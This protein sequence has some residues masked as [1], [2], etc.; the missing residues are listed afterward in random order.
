[1]IV[2][3]FEKKN[4]PSGYRGEGFLKF[5]ID[6]RPRNDRQWMPSDMKSSHGPLV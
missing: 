3:K 4:S 6:H 5:T 1:M 2:A